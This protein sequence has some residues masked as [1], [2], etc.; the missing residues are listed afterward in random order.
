[1]IR[2][3][4]PLLRLTPEA[5]GKLQHDYDRAITKLAQ[6]EREHTELQNQIRTQLGAETL[7]KLRTDTRNAVL[8]VDLK[9]EAA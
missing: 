6:L 5:A 7:W 3:H 8:L 9:K 2:R 4:F 1:M